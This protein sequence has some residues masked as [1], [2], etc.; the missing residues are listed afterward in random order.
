MDRKDDEG[1]GFIE[2]WSVCKKQTWPRVND[3]D[4]WTRNCWNVCSPLKYNE[5]INCARAGNID[6]EEWKGNNL[7]KIQ[8][9]KRF[10]GFQLA[11]ESFSDFTAIIQT[12]AV[13]LKKNSCVLVGRQ[14]GWALWRPAALQF[15]QFSLISGRLTAESSSSGKQDRPVSARQGNLRNILYLEPSLLTHYTTAIIK[16][17]QTSHVSRRS[18]LHCCNKV[19]ERIINK[20]SRQMSD[21]AKHRWDD[22]ANHRIN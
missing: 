12:Q 11:S 7:R 9:M 5:N 17:A 2:T 8:R 10:E 19:T 13:T 1:P 6:W 4:G 20:Q 21:E 18:D 3:E 15:K 22:Q 16:A 14:S